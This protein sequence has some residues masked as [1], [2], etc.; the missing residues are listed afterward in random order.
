VNVE[1]DDNSDQY[2][3]YVS[4]R[5][6]NDQPKLTEPYQASNRQII[7][8]EEL[9]KKAQEARNK[10]VKRAFELCKERDLLIYPS[11][12]QKQESTS[13][14]NDSSQQ[15]KKKKKKVNFLQVSDSNLSE[16][17]L[18]YA[19]GILQSYCT[20]KND[21]SPKYN[22]ISTDQRQYIYTCTIS[23]NITVKTEAFNRKK[24]AKKSAALLMCQHI[25]RQEGSIEAPSS[26]L[27]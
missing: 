16:L 22:S 12:S 27:Q 9:T 23:G 11:F 24:D 19:I 14:D 18:E 20:R 15:L 7:Y 3:G 26:A 21:S 10:A 1:Q 17:N 6:Q 13:H 8:A 25:I 4:I 2:L 5:I